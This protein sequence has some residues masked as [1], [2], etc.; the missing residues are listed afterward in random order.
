MPGLSDTP[1]Y[2]RSKVKGP[3]EVQGVLQ[4]AETNLMCLNTAVTVW[5]GAYITC[6]SSLERLET[7]GFGF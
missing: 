5:R 6:I 2:Q 1:G 3:G 4:Q 7:T